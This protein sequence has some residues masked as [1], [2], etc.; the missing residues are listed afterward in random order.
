MPDL[1]VLSPRAGALRDA[2][3]GRLPPQ[4]TAHY[5]SDPAAL[6]DAARAAEIALGTPDALAAVLPQLP[7]LRWLQCSWAGVEPL[8][9][10]RRRDYWLTNARGIFGA[11]MSE[12]VLGWLLALRRGILERARTRRWQ[13]RPDPGLSSLRLGI[14]GVGAIG[15][16]VAARCA[17]FVGEVVGLNS[18]GRPVPGCARCYPAAQRLDFARGL[19]ALVLL[20]PHTAATAGFADHALL[21][22]LAPGALVIS[23]GRAATLQLSPA[24]EMLDDGTLSA[25]VLDVLPQEPLPAGDALWDRERV[26]ITSHSAA[27]TAIAPLLALFL[28]NLERYLDGRELRARVDFER[29]Y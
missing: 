26:Y 21:A 29:G 23:A 6:T 28:D 13:P 10:A 2:L 27:P 19:D 5:C 16:V 4:V 20:L 24:L 18:D 12:Y 15:A 22:C 3:A 1:L 8:L 7:R 14:A 25:L 17:P 11:P 9:R